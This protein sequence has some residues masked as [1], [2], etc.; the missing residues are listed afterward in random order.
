MKIDRGQ[1]VSD[2]VNDLNNSNIIID[3]ADQVKSLAE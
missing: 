2:V 1:E 3:K